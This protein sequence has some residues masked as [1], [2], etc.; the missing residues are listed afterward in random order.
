MLCWIHRVTIIISTKFIL[1]WLS[2]TEF[3]RRYMKML[4][5]KI[6]SWKKYQQKIRKYFDIFPIKYET[7]FYSSTI[8][9][10]TISYNIV[11]AISSEKWNASSTSKTPL[12]II[13]CCSYYSIAIF[14][15]CVYNN[16]IT[17]CYNISSRYTIVEVE[18]KWT[19]PTMPIILCNLCPTRA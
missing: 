3:I 17:I 11:Y 5:W 15:C 1:K 4:L 2:V 19:S 14:K 18:I 12:C 9:L 16:I 8:I 13:I 7:D 10:Q 6:W